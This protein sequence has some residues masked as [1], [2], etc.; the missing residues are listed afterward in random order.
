MFLC[1]MFNFP[2]SLFP[3]SL[4]M[5]RGCHLSR[6]FSIILHLSLDVSMFLLSRI[7]CLRHFIRCVSRF[8]CFVFVY[9]PLCFAC[10]PSDP[11][12]LLSPLVSSSFSRFP[13]QY[14]SVLLSLVY[15]YLVVFLLSLLPFIFVSCSVSLVEVPGSRRSIAFRSSLLFLVSP[16]MCSS[17]CACLVFVVS[18]FLCVWFLLPRCFSILRSR[19]S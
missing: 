14:F 7:S 10:F 16:S 5:R 4:F 19:L 18:F 1:H 11:S 12:L 17:P 13:F 6:L 2:V 9:F 15:V 3:S 8:L